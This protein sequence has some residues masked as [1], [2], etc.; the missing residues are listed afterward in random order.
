MATYLE[1]S[2]AVAL[3]SGVVGGTGLPTS[4]L[5]QAQADLLRVVTWVRDAWVEIQVGSI[6]W[7]FLEKRFTSTAVIANTP[8]YTAGT[9]GITDF[10]RWLVADDRTSSGYSDGLTLYQTSIGAADEAPLRVIDWDEY[11]R[12]WLRGTHAASRPRDAAVAP[13][14]A[15]WLGPTPDAAYTLRGRYERTAQVLAA[16]ADEPLCPARFHN[17]IKFHAL[18]KLAGFDE[19]LVARAAAE[20]QYRPLLSALKR[21]Q[22]PMP[23]FRPDPLA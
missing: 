9:L 2:Q 8:E 5:N 7:R 22:L 10:G 23:R 19:A 15:L 4:V 3:E 13:D 21:D 17:A 14:N 1:I 11:L 6:G 12:L 20:A 16:N 18:M